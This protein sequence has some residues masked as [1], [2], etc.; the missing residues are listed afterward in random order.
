MKGIYITFI[1]FGL[2]W[3]TVISRKGEGD[4]GEGSEGSP[5]KQSL[6]HSP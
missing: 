5:A 1:R 4:G 2:V 3:L 6:I